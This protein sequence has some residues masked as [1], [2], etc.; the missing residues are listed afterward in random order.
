MCICQAIL[1]MAMHHEKQTGIKPS[2]RDACKIYTL[3]MPTITRKF[4]SVY[5]FECGRN[6][7]QFEKGFRTSNA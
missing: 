7:A 1:N 5:D 3:I 2:E 6:V 4:S